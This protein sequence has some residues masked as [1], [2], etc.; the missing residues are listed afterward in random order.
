MADGKKKALN[1]QYKVQM[2]QSTGHIWTRQEVDA[3][4]DFQKEFNDYVSTFNSLLTYAAEIYGIYYDINSL[5]NTLQWLGREI[6]NHPENAFAVA[7]STRK[8]NIYMKIVQT[9]ED[10]LY[11]TPTQLKERELKSMEHEVWRCP[12]CKTTKLMSYKGQTAGKYEECPE[13]KA[14]AYET[15]DRLTLQKATYTHAGERKDTKRCAVC[16]FVGTAMVVLPMLVRAASTSSG[17]GGGFGGGGGRS[18]GGG[19]WGGGHSF[20]GGAGRSF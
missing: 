10:E 9:G 18:S 19:S 5:A 17:G 7:L 3:V 11:L 14:H 6:D 4:T 2:L 1:A 16:G 15:I 8:N 13:C 12:E 20:G